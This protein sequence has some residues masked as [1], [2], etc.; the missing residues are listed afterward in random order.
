[1]ISGFHHNVDMTCALLGYY[2][3]VIKNPR[4]LTLEDR[5]DTLSQNVSMELPLYAAQY[6]RRVKISCLPYLA[7]HSMIL[8]QEQ[9]LLSID[10]DDDHAC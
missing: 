6:S 4:F 7:C 3:M 8:H 2:I 10:F 9:R 1:M 5:T